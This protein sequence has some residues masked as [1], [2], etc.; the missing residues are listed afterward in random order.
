MIRDVMWKKMERLTSSRDPVPRPEVLVLRQRGRV[1]LATPGDLPE[2]PVDNVQLVLPDRL[3][4]VAHAVVD[5]RA[6]AQG[7]PG[8]GLVDDLGRDEALAGV[9]LCARVAAARYGL[10]YVPE[11]GYVLQDHGDAEGA[12]YLDLFGGDFSEFDCVSGGR[13]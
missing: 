12:D 1:D 9:V 2:L 5:P 13:G 7:R 6:V 11:L 4:P 10:G 3:G 8:R